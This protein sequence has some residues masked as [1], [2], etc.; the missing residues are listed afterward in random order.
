MRNDRVLR[1]LP[2]QPVL[3]GAFTQA[4]V[5]FLEQQAQQDQPFFLYLAHSAPHY[6]WRVAGEHRGRSERGLYGDVVERIDWGVGEVLDALERL[7]LAEDTLVIFASDNGPW[8]DASVKAGSAYP[9][10]GGKADSWEGGVRAPMI[11]RWPGVLPAGRTTDALVT[12]LDLLPTIAGV[13]G[14][15]LPTQPIDG[16]DVWPALAGTGPSP[17]ESFAY[18]ARGRLEAMRVGDHKRVYANSARQVPVT[19]ALYDLSADPGEQVDLASARPDLVKTID[20]R[21]DAIRAELGDAL[22][23]IVGRATR[24]LGS[25]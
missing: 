2:E 6:P 16:V 3:V 22:T 4:A 5:T 7:G 18:Y 23:G 11:A 20:A 13:A 10:R 17:R 9:F 14:A 19:E 1:R 12:A 15:S 21:A 25:G 8:L 24:P